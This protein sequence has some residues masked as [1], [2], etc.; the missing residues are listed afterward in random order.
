MQLRLLFTVVHGQTVLRC[1]FYGYL[2]Q[3]LKMMEKIFTTYLL[4]ALIL[5][6]SVNGQDNYDYN[7]EEEG[8]D[9]SRFSFGIN[10]GAH[11]A[12]RN[13]AEIYSGRPN[14]TTF[15]VEHVLFEQ[16]FFRQ[17]IDAYFNNNLFTVEEYPIEER[18]RVASEIGFHVDYSIGEQKQN[19]IFLDFNIAQLRYEQFFTVG[20]DDPLNQSP[21]PL[22]FEQVPIF[23]EENRFYLNLGVQLSLYADEQS[24]AYFSLF[25]SLNNTQMR[26]NYFVLGEREYDIFHIA[27]DRPNQRLG[28][29]GY[30]GG[31][32]LGYKFELMEHLDADIYYNLYYVQNNFKDDFQPFGFHNAIGLRIIWH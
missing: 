28:G 12:N 1:L 29:V 17:E 18:Y 9:S 26:R 21:E 31:T 16:Q 3:E 24:N 6:S 30:G 32:G 25:G 7:Y 27:I 14:I 23:G 22:R 4:A 2:A 11:F 20:I 13:T 5:S 10:F 8:L 15:G 19:A